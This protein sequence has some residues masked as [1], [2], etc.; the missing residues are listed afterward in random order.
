[1]QITQGQGATD[2]LLAGV[3]KGVAQARLWLS[4]AKA[5]AAGSLH[6]SRLLWPALLACWHNLFVH[7]TCSALPDLQQGSISAGFE[8]LSCIA[9]WHSPTLVPAALRPACPAARLHLPPASLAGT[10][11]SVPDMLCSACPAARLHLCGG[12]AAYVRRPPGCAAVGWPGLIP[13]GQRGQQVGS[14][15]T[16]SSLVC[17]EQCH[18]KQGHSTRCVVGKHSKAE[19]HFPEPKGNGL[20]YGDADATCMQHTLPDKTEL[21]TP[22]LPEPCHVPHVATL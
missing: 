11:I 15:V 20:I 4:R 10:A 12:E 1:M 2:K 5:T 14:Q 8:H 18:A 6:A 13:C 3:G 19:D 16:G 21:P 17:G 22:V 9:C 7:L